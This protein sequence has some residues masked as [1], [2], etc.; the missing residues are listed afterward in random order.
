MI[1]EV[2]GHENN[3]EKISLGTFSVPCRLVLQSEMSR[4]ESTQEELVDRAIH[5]DS[6]A[7]ETLV[8]PH[9]PSV[10]R[11][12]FAFCHQ[13]D[14]ADEI[15]QEALLKAYRSLKTFRGGNL[16]PWI[17][18]VTRSVCHDWYRQQRSRGRLT[19]VELNE[20]QDLEP[21][22]SPETLLGERSQNEKLWAAIRSLDPKFRVPLVLFEIEGLSYEEVARIESA[23]IGTIRSRLSRARKQ[24][25][26]LMQIPSIPP[27][28]GTLSNEFA[29]TFPRAEK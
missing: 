2:C 17:Y 23:P 16:G 25:L 10:R 11:I 21:S 3:F 6:P 8:A 1:S 29:S 26:V 5:G 20:E 4:A 13:R 27:D 12:A 15:A 18:S 9:I 19:E 7:F 28:R 14:S 22:D 24:L